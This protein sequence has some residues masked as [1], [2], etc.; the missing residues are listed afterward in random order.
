[1]FSDGRENT[2]TQVSDADRG[3]KILTK[4]MGDLEGEVVIILLLWTI[5]LLALAFI[6]LLVNFMLGTKALK[7]VSFHLSYMMLGPGIGYLDLELLASS[8][9][10]LT[11][12]LANI[13]NQTVRVL[14]IVLG[15]FDLLLS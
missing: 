11:L 15:A 7:A 9:L 4:R 1:M 12:V 6:D 14:G 8:I 3:T 10:L 13:W 2:G 5:T